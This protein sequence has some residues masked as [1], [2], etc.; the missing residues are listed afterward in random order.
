M[1]PA[2]ITSQIA[3]K[4]NVPVSETPAS[5]AQNL[6]DTSPVTAKSGSPA[7]Q[8]KETAK[9][10]EE[11]PANNGRPKGAAKGII[12]SDSA[13]ANVEADVLDSFRNFANMEKMRVSDH[14]RQRVSHDKAIKLNDLMKFSKNFNLKTPVPKDLVPILAKDKSKQEEIMERAQRN[15][16]QFSSPSPNSTSVISDQKVLKS[17]PEGPR[18]STQASPNVADRQDYSSVRHG[19]QSQIQQA[20]LPLTD[21]QLPSQ[22]I[23]LTSDKPA[24]GYLGHRLH[25]NH[26]Q[27]K[28]GMR[29]AVPPPIPIHGSSRP[30]IRPAVG[31]TSSS[32]TPS[33]VRTPTSAVSSKFNIKAPEFKPN[34]AASTF[35][36]SN[37]PSAI[38]T[39]VSTPSARPASRSHTPTALFGSRKPLPASERPSINE[40][41]NPLK[42]LKENAVNEGKAKD[43]SSN[44]SIKYAFTTTPTWKMVRDESPMKSYAEMFEDVAPTSDKISLQPVY[45][46]NSA[47]PHQHQLP[48][49]LQQGHGGGMPHLQAPNPASF[50]VQPQVQHYPSG[51]HHYDDHRMHLP[52]SNSTPYQ[53]S[54]RMQNNTMAFPSPMQQ[55]AQLAYGQPVPHYVMGPHGPQPAQFRPG[56]PQMMPTQGP[57]LAAPMMVQ[58]S[59]QN[60]FIAPSHGMAVPFNPQMQVFP[61]GQPSSYNGQ[62]QPPS[63]YPSPGR[64]APMM[65]HQN[66]HQG[67]QPIYMNPNQYGQPMYAQQQPPHSRSKSFDTGPNLATNTLLVIPMRAYGSPQ[68][69][70]AQS[71][72]PHYNFPP[73]PH[74]VPNTSYGQP[75][76]QGPHHH[77]HQHQ[78]QHMQ[79][80]PPNMPVENGEEAK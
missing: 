44:G 55:P 17:V 69:H 41:F 20:T 32:Q 46:V 77:Q 18:E 71:P 27:H 48:H 39:P 2:I 10:G 74:R 61:P 37:G 19:Y 45:Q 7:E 56:G 3:R 68:S 50:P 80:P 51:Q 42:R 15:A 5:S 64:G 33:S 13:T 29:V 75:P 9:A 67:Q 34:P 79:H 58:Q 72:Q 22:N 49:H 59:S 47:V 53:P 14:R 31:Q 73:Q 65:M 26:G 25:E 28:A 52:A 43:Y 70:Y 1:D 16:Q 8:P 23:P 76:P 4:D 11:A 35:R 36:P 57:Q 63:G 38:S 54:P 24:Q 60:G 78:H 66:S 12:P 30:T 62:S 6:A 40:N 21:R